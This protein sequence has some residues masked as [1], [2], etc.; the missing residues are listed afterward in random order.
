MFVCVSKSVPLPPHLCVNSAYE[1]CHLNQIPC[2]HSPPPSRP[3]TPVPSPVTLLAAFPPVLDPVRPLVSV[4]AHPI[5]LDSLSSR[6]PALVVPSLENVAPTPALCSHARPLV[7]AL[8]SK[9]DRHPYSAL[10]TQC[11]YFPVDLDP[12]AHC[13]SITISAINA[14]S[15]LDSFLAS[16]QSCTIAAPLTQPN[17]PTT[18]LLE[19]YAAEEIPVHV[20]GTLV[21]GY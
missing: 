20:G 13:F 6:K 14:A 11:A 18:T 5:A 8:V 15:S 1:V 9:P 16:C 21:H 3:S 4:S 19:I 7:P 10:R 17:H 12:I 2:H